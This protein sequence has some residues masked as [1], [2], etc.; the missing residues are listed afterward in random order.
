MTAGNVGG[1]VNKMSMASLDNGTITLHPG[2]GTGHI[3][4]GQMHPDA[5]DPAL[6][7]A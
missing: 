7:S 6:R 2:F 4:I 3:S 5:E 1:R